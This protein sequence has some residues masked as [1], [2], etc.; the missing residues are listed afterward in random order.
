MNTVLIVSKVRSDCT[1]LLADGVSNGDDLER[2]THL[3][4]LEMADEY[5]QPQT[6]NQRLR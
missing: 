3:T 5:T 6:A 1:T 2:L 4:F